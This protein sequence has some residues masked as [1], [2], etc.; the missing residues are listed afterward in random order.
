MKKGK[1]KLNPWHIPF[2]HLLI[3]FHLGSQN[4]FSLWN[5]RWSVFMAPQVLKWESR[6]WAAK[7]SEKEQ[8]W[9]AEAEQWVL[10]FSKEG[11]C[12]SVLYIIN[13]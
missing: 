7:V 12:I 11:I 5:V 1:K 4:E 6:Q 3:V 9:G 10:L 8:L 2:Q 13:V